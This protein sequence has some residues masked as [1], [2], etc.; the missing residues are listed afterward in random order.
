MVSS[1]SDIETRM[2]SHRFYQLIPMVDDK[3]I[4][5][6]QSN[7]VP[8]VSVITCVLAE[9]LR[10]CIFTGV[11]S[12]RKSVQ[13]SEIQSLLPS[14]AFL[15]RTTTE[16]TSSLGRT[17]SGTSPEIRQR[18][19]RFPVTTERNCHD[20][21]DL[22][23]LRCLDCEPMTLQA[24]E[25]SI[26]T[27]TADNQEANRGRNQGRLGVAEKFSTNPFP[28]TPDRT[29]REGVGHPLRGTYL[30]HPPKGGCR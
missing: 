7:N 9:S 11:T 2:A 10:P 25:K 1:R 3:V 30:C 19:P 22:Q 8:E 16:L 17:S 15:E 20:H 6:L 14:G 27:V 4:G 29:P 18:S 28:R 21:E 13:R 5:E 23:L 24:I 12:Q 26:P